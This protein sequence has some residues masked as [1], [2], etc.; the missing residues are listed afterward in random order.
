[1]G[2]QHSDAGVGSTNTATH[3]ATH[4]ATRCNT[5]QNLLEH[6]APHHNTPQ[7]AAT[8]TATH[9]YTLE[10]TLQTQVGMRVKLSAAGRKHKDLT[11]G[12]AVDLGVIQDIEPDGRLCQVLWRSGVLQC[13]AVC[14]SVLQCAAVCYSVSQCV[15]VCCTGRPP[16]PSPLALWCVAVFFSV[17]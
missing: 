6:T 10:H 7:N 13:A 3:T 2:P 9:C 15:A 11:E 5:Q 12:D 14:C 1:M 16:L 8:R 17:L 4:T